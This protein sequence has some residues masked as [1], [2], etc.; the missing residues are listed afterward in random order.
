MGRGEE[1]EEVVVERDPEV[2]VPGR[3]RRSDLCHPPVFARDCLST[4]SSSA[5]LKWLQITMLREVDRR[6]DGGCNL[7]KDGIDAGNVYRWI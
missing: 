6:E 2:R 1:E 4:H 5:P 7:T 3:I